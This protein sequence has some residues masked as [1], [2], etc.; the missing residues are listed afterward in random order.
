MSMD[1]I[2]QAEN[3]L[4]FYLKRIRSMNIQLHVSKKVTS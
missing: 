4:P 1:R 2:G 3:N